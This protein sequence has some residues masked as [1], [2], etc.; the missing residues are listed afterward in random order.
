[1]DEAEKRL[2]CIAGNKAFKAGNFTCT[3][4]WIVSLVGSLVFGMDIGA[5]LMVCIIWF[6]LSMTYIFEVM[7]LEK[8]KK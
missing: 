4:L 8:K 1:M 2:R 7:K 3:I 5:L 6:V